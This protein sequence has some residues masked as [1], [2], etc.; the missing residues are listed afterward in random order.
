MRVSRFK[1]H[2]LVLFAALI[3]VYIVSGKGHTAEI[4]QRLLCH[5]IGIDRV[6]EK[7]LVSI[8]V[9]KPSEP[10]SDTPVDITKSNVEVITASGKTVAEAI[11]QCERKRGK[12]VFLGH[13][14]L[15]CLGKSVDVSQP[16]ELF[17][18]CLSDK[19]V[20]LSADVCAAEDSARELIQTELT[21]EMIST[22]NFIDV[23]RHN[24]Q[25]SRCA[26]CRLIDMLSFVGKPDFALP[27]ISVVKSDDEKRPPE[28]AIKRTALIADG[29][30]TGKGIDAACTGWFMTQPQCREANTALEADNRSVDVFVEKA[31]CKSGVE[32]ENG[33]LVCKVELEVTARLGSDVG[34]RIRKNAEEEISQQLKKQIEDSFEMCEKRLGCDVLGVAKQMRSSFPKTYLRYENEIGEILGAARCVAIVK[35]K[36]V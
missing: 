15:I 27:E 14:K 30:F 8:Q 1:A 32:I 6:G 11:A 23:I 5:A 3:I 7:Y 26:R 24:V 25:L 22:E 20:C 13:L 10:G 33:Q 19:T 36:A 9:F 18:F 34:E 12:T 17:A 21:S 28:L 35:C 4:Q 29:K 31:R 2:T 16:E